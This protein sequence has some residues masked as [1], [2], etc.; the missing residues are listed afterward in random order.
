MNLK[1]INKFEKKNPTIAA[2]VLGFDESEKNIAYPLRVS[3]LVERK[4]IVNFLLLENQLY[5]LSKDL[6]KLLSSQL[7]NHHEKKSFVWGV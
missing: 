1:D 6:S 4:T 7:S 2:N 5:C 3:K